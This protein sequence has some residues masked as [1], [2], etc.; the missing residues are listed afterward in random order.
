MIRQQ[1]IENSNNDNNV[2]LDESKLMETFKITAGSQGNKPYVEIQKELMAKSAEKA[3]KRKEEELQRE[4]DEA[5]KRRQQKL[6][7]L[8]ERMRKKKEMEEKKNNEN[9][10]KNE[11]KKDEMNDKK[12]EKLD[13]KKDNISDSEKRINEKSI[14]EGKEKEG[15]IG[16]NQMHN[17]GLKS[18]SSEK[19]ISKP[20]IA[21]KNLNPSD[22][23]KIYETSE[24]NY[25]DKNIDH[26]EKKNDEISKQ[27]TKSLSVKQNNT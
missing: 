23:S 20:L 10:V 14:I 18:K 2:A 13:E 5:E 27:N 19:S 4:R 26:E 3:R 8:E 12:D 9:I 1:P 6:K 17:Q 11:E 16:Q 24:T 7:E 15:K 22:S 25:E 21:N